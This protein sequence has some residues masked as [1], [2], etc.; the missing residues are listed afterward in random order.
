MTS[1][2]INSAD[3][4]PSATSAPEPH[5]LVDHF[6]RHEYAQL[7]ATLTR[8]FGV[9]NWELV[10]DVV[11][12][13]LERA[14]SSWSRK[15]VP[16]NPGGWLHRVAVNKAL[17]V[18]RRDERWGS[19]D[20]RDV[21][22]SG[23]GLHGP[24]FNDDLLR[25]IF[26]CCDPCVPPESQIALALKALCGFGNREIARALLTTEASVAKRVT[27]AKQRLREEGVEPSEPGDVELKD[28][29]S[30]VQAVV[31]LLFNEGYSST[32]VDKPIREE[33]CE[34]AVRLALVLAE[35]PTTKCGSSSAML[36]L[37]LFH[38]ARLEAR[39]DDH[40]TI[41]LLKEQ[42]RSQW[43]HRLLRE[44][45]RW[46]RRGYDGD[47]VTRYHAEAW[48]ASEH[49]R[50]RRFEDTNWDNIAKGYDLLCQIEPSPVHKLNRAIAIGHRD[51][52]EAGLAAFAAI[53]SSELAQDYYLWHAT[54]AHL[55]KQTGDIEAARTA[56]ETAWKLAPTN[57]EKEL[58]SRKLDLL[59][60]EP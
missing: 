7:V 24:A 51:G 36:S 39:L 49:C 13:A 59:T 17:D 48:I 3:A 31:Y 57:A 28:R 37:L 5:Q 19:L 25:M 54:H 35:H 30:H 47:Q 27:R 8:R 23:D 2:K 21:Q 45:F 22:A 12:S 40:G 1:P 58:I 15:G 11:Q 42:D 29:L 10:E 41:L 20:D 14:L 50:A 43:D 46:F 53:E 34:E 26:V 52:A 6:F 60:S 32:T 33:L 16:D 4:S 9:G 44:A 38:A 56:L 55:A 18:L